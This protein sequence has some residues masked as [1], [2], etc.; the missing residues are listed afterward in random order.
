MEL[1]YP[2]CS[3][4]ILVLGPEKMN[5]SSDK[6]QTFSWGLHIPSWKQPMAE[7]QCGD[8]KLFPLY[9]MIGLSD[10]LVCGRNKNQPRTTLKKFY[11]SGDTVRSVTL[12]KTDRICAFHMVVIPIVHIF[13][14]SPVICRFCGSCR[15]GFW[16][17][18]MGQPWYCSRR[19][20]LATNIWWLSHRMMSP[21]RKSSFWES[22][23]SMAP[24]HTLRSKMEN[25]QLLHA[26]KSSNFV[27]L[28]PKSTCTSEQW[29]KTVYNY[30]YT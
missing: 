19:S 2:K 11:D 9:R 16:A 15:F 18:I 8:S 26:G 10:V 30:P 20:H 27:F 1:D 21:H 7:I 5:W 3:S 12:M 24:K 17:G 22:M 14:G 23:I 28:I 29:R 25:P 13:C 4:G 6:G